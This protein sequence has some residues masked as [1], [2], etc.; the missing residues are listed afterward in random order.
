MTRIINC[1]PRPA[2]EQ[3]QSHP[4]VGTV[5]VKIKML[6]LQKYVQ[7]QHPKYL[8]IEYIAFMRS[9]EKVVKPVKPLLGNEREVTAII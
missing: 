5:P 7:F 4:I 3:T 6:E 8:A 1:D 9:L 2:S